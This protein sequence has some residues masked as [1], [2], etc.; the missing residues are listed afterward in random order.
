MFHAYQQN[1]QVPNH[2]YSYSVYSFTT[3]RRYMLK[4]KSEQPKLRFMPG[5]NLQNLANLADSGVDP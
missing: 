4:M 5:V 2:I 1:P 3:E